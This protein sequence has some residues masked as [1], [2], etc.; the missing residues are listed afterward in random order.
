MFIVYEPSFGDEFINIGTEYLCIS[1]SY[2]TVDS[3]DG[4]SLV[5][6]KDITPSLNLRLAIYAPPFGTT[7]A[8]VNPVAGCN[9]SLI[10]VKEI[11]TS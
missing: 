3:H 6:L 1:M 5:I 9:L 11:S 2:P 4:L 10:L 7:R 8:K